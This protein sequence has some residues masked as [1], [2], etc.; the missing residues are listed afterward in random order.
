[1]TTANE[2]FEKET[3][4]LFHGSSVQVKHPQFGVGNPRNDYGLGFYTTELH[5]LAFEW[6]CPGIKDGWVNEYALDTR[7]LSVID[8][9]GPEFTVLNW[10]AVL[11]EHRKIS[12]GVGIAD[13]ARAFVIEN[14]G[15]DLTSADIVHGYRADDSCFQI[16]RSFLNNRISVEVLEQSL[17]LGGLG[18]QVA[19][20][21]DVAFS[22]LSWLGAE[23]AQA[24]TWHPRRVKRDADARAVALQLQ[25][26][27]LQQRSGCY[28]IDIMRGADPW[29]K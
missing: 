9:S 15:V 21:S 10:M 16:A 29:G 8:L 2:F 26:D 5:E 28:I 23:P 6:A 14:Y 7:G 11:L 18:Y 13:E 20:L 19:I 25:A 24:R 4:T 27:S 1:M 3:I 17:F 22:H 12:L